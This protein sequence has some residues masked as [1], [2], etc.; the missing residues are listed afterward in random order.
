MLNFLWRVVLFI[1][2]ID[3]FIIAVGGGLWV[4]NVWF[5]EMFKIDLAKK[6]LNKLNEEHN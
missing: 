4:F 1:L 2:L 5:Y 6:I 3:A